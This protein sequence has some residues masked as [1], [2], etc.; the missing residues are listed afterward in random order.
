MTTEEKPSESTARS[1]DPAVPKFMAAVE[2]P[3]TLR[4]E[5]LLTSKWQLI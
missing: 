1:L 5:F 2:M 4:G 3:V